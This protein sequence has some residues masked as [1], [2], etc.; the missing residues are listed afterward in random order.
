MVKLYRTTDKVPIKIDKIKFYISPLQ[1][2]H[3]EEIQ[4]ELLKAQSDPMA[5]V[6]AAKLSI[7]YSVK[8]VDGVENV[9]GS[10]FELEFENEV[11]TEQ[12]VSD[13]L[14]IDQDDKL[15]FVCTSFLNGIPKDF[16]DPVTGEKLKGVSIVRE[17]S[18]KK[19]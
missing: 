1:Y 7:Q 8:G 6:R 13:L 9:D 12:S 11:L 16:I 4:A 5:V 10:K 17:S 19:R 3:K 18:S 2:S 14:N 15:S